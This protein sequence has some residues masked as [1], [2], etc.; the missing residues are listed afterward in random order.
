MNPYDLF[1]PYSQKIRGDLEK[2]LRECD[3]G[4]ADN[5]FSGSKYFFVI[6]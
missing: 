4:G 1:K 6:K 5:M 3:E 2:Y